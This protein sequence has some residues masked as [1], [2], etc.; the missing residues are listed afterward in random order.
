MPETYDAPVQGRLSG[1]RILVVEDEFVIAMQL[2]SVFEEE[3]AQVLGPYHNLAEA[4]EHAGTDDITAA[5]LD[6]NLGRDTAAPVA[7][8]LAERKVPF[9]FYSVQTNDP[10]IADWRH[11]PLIQKPAAPSDLIDA[12]ATVLRRRVSESAD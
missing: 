9:V 2:Q 1:A 12:I 7:S 10:A 4:L 5:S 3:G 6:V 8:L 11:I